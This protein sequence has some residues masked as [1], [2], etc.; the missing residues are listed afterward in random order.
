ME[1]VLPCGGWRADVTE[2]GRDR[3]QVRLVAALEESREALLPL[4]VWLPITAQL[5][6]VD[7]M[8]P[9]LVELGA[10]FLQPV[11]YAR[12]EYDARKALARSDRWQRI[13]LAACEQSHRTR[14]P[15]LRAPVAF[16]ALLTVASPQ[17]WVAYERQTEHRNPGLK[18]EAITITSGP[19]GGFTD[20]EFEAL[21]KASWEPVCL[22]LGIL[23]AITAPVALLGAIQ[24][25]LNA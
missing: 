25:Q 18:R 20:A 8:L 15:E 3:A 10:T 1:V 7:E 17:K 5:S 4:Q 11:I 23:R 21:L 13:V 19:E 24:H 9:P 12:S 6:L 22:G 14:V 2:A 16:E